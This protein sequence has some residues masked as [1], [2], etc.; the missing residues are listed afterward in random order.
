[1]LYRCVHP[2]CY[3]SRLIRSSHRRPHADIGPSAYSLLS[4]SKSPGAC[5]PSL[6]DPLSPQY[7]FI[8]RGLVT[9]LLGPTPRIML[10]A[11]VGQ[12]IIMWALS[13][14]YIHDRRGGLTLCHF[15]VESSIPCE[16][17]DA[18]TSFLVVNVFARRTNSTRLIW[19]PAAYNCECTSWNNGLTRTWIIYGICSV[20]VNYSELFQWSIS[21]LV[22]THK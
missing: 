1:M 15:V 4:P 8:M 20:A 14:I 2:G 17:S 13:P 12:L 11:Q 19:P 18:E 9:T 21:M 10:S 16:A 3:F 5:W 22:M 6:I 7:P